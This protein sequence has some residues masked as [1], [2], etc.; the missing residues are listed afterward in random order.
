VVADVA[1]EH[2]GRLVTR[3]T[4]GGGGALLELPLAR[5]RAELRIVPSPGEP[6]K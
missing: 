6:A 3:R 1:A 4:D 2:G 5:P